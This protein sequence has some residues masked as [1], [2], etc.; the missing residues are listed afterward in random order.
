MFLLNMLTLYPNRSLVRNTGMDG[1]GT[2]SSKS[3]EYHV[4]LAKDMVSVGN[5]E[6]R[7]S[8]KALKALKSFRVRNRKR[9]VLKNR[10]RRLI[11]L[12]VQKRET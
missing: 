11:N 9:N 8:K 7:E 12:I 4:K 1:S 3:R 10:L 6:I 5:I 2:H